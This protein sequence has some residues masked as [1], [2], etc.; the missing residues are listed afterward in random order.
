MDSQTTEG[1]TTAMNDPT[2]FDAIMLKTVYSI[3][4]LLGI[5]GNSL[6]IYLVVKVPSLRSVTNVLICN[7]ALIDLTSSIF[8]VCFY[9]VPEPPL[10]ESTA[11][12]SVLC[13][14]WLSG[15]PLW[16]FSVSS[17]VNLVLLTLERYFA[18]MHPIKYRYRFSMRRAKFLAII[19]W[20]VG[21]LHELGW[22]LVQTVDSEGQCVPLWPSVILQCVLGVV[23]FTGHYMLP[24]TL[25]VYVYTKI[26]LKLRSDWRSSTTSPSRDAHAPNNNAPALNDPQSSEYN[27]DRR[28][29]TD[30][31]PNSPVP[32]RRHFS[33][34]ASKSVLRTLLIV[35]ASYIV[36]WG[37]NEIIYLLFNLGVPVEFGGLYHNLSVIFVLCNMCL[38]PIVYAF[39][40]E[41]LK[42]ALRTTLPTC[43]MNGKLRMSCCSECCKKSKTYEVEGS[44][45]QLATVTLQDGAITR[46]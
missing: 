17:T 7:Q 39:H 44:E 31:A 2:P 34:L 37:P 9:L 8:F 15:W 14:L 20:F 19:P 21:P 28:N 24:V 33:L 22:A 29:T 36:C 23:F 45:Q 30:C 42:R 35:S 12:A 38:N 27:S 18:I 40:Y 41:E 1:A 25:M 32:R 6:V 43:E 16:G 10:P 46:L 11:A 26:I 3:I 13:K 4:G 5:V